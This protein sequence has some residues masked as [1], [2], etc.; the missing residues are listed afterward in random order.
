MGGRIVGE[1]AVPNCCRA[2]EYEVQGPSTVGRVLAEGAAGDVGD[3][4]IAA[5]GA[6]I[7]GVVFDE[8]AVIDRETRPL[9]MNRAARVA[10]LVL[11]EDAVVERGCSPGIPAGDRCIPVLGED[12]R[13]D[14]GATGSLNQDGSAARVHRDPTTGHRNADQ[15]RFTRLRGVEMESAVRIGLAALTVDETGFRTVLGSYGDRLA[16]IVDI[17]VAIPGESPIGQFDDVAVYRGIDGR[18]NRRVITCAIRPH[19]VGVRNDPISPGQDSATQYK[20]PY[21]HGCTSHWPSIPVSVSRAG[22]ICTNHLFD[23]S[24]KSLHK[25]RR[26]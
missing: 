10:A 13:T 2:G 14:A 1:Q 9:A 21:S 26:P 17:P 16:Q 6:P 7:D 24:S 20:R 8:V 25:T 18:L 22:F 5:N 4:G 23:H 15:P 11:P 3:T 12:A 19:R